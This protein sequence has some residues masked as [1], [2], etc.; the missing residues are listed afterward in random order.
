MSATIA[1]RSMAADAEMERARDDEVPDGHAAV[2]GRADEGRRRA[3]ADAEA[4][5]EGVAEEDLARTLGQ[6]AADDG[7]VQVEE[8]ALGAFRRAQVDGQAGGRAL[9]PGLALLVGDVDE[10]A[11]LD[12]RRPDETGMVP[13]ELREKRAD[14]GEGQVVRSQVGFLGIGPG[15][16]LDVAGREVGARLDD[17]RDGAVEPA[18]ADDGQH[19]AEEDGHERQE[20][21]RA[22]AEKPLEE[23]ADHVIR[24]LS[25]SVGLSLAILRVG[26][27]ETKVVVRRTRSV[28]PATRPTP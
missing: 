4:R 24:P 6:A 9:G 18:E 1:P 16:D 26:R 27:N 25:A 13:L 20:A 21:A 7:F 5:G 28:V 15:H 22:V 14:A 8:P 17:G 23:E 19:G 12:A 2:H 3:G 10:A 11:E